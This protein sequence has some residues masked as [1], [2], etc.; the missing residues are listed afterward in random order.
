MI[1][2]GVRIIFLDVDGVLN[3]QA[4]YDRYLPFGRP[5]PRPPLDRDAVRRLDRLIVAT[6]AWIVLSTSWRGYSTLPGWLVSHGCRGAVVG[7]TP[8]RPAPRGVEIATWLNAA[9]RRGVPI[10]RFAI[11]DDD[12]DMGALAPYLVQTDHRYGLQDED[13]DRAIDLLG[14]R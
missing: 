3:S 10:Q 14:R 13:V 4:F 9:A 6:G 2:N 11:L 1:R 12:A 8:F 7:R 5:V